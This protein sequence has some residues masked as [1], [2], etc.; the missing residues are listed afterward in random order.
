LVSQV[1]RHNEVVFDDKGSLLVVK[2][3]SLQHSGADD[4]LLTI[5]IG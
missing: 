4:T 3:E 5:K 2:N 1:C